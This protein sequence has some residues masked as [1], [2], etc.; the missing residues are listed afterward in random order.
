MCRKGLYFF[1]GAATVLLVPTFLNAEGYSLPPVECVEVD[2]VLYNS[3]PDWMSY[4][5][6]LSSDV[7]NPFYAA[8]IL[9]LSRDFE[10][11][12]KEFLF[13]PLIP[14]AAFAPDIIERNTG[15][16]P[17][18]LRS[19]AQLLVN[20]FSQHGIS[21]IDL[22]EAAAAMPDGVNYHR[23]TDH[24]WTTEGAARSA[25]LVANKMGLGQFL[26]I[27]EWQDEYLTFPRVG[28]KSYLP[29][30]MRSVVVD[31]CQLE[32]FGITFDLIDFPRAESSQSVGED[33]LFGG[34]GE[35]KIAVLGSSYTAA[36]VGNAFP[37][38]LEHYAQTT[39]L[40]YSIGGGGAATSLHQFTS[41]DGIQ[42]DSVS[43]VVWVPGTLSQLDMISGAALLGS[44]SLEQECSSDDLFYS[45]RILEANFDEWVLLPE[46]IGLTDRIEIDSLKNVQVEFELTVTGYEPIVVNAFFGGGHNIEEPFKWQFKLP[47]AELREIADA[48]IETV[49]VRI[50]GFR[51]YVPSGP[52][53]FG[54]TACSSL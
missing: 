15:F 53:S 29:P 41:G 44:G 52:V 34:G 21:S 50:T 5:S 51:D 12:G 27:F 33:A 26:S 4:R 9:Q 38:A 24:H 42:N 35:M 54:V 8:S 13:L 30:I 10:D 7:Y 20:T 32:D 18:D 2:R 22:S 14:P 36:D 47:V 37:K 48:E 31:D 25:N 45:E 1:L 49:Q 11:L 43:N 6:Y 23:L 16:S 39:V 28:Q 19:S 40:D 46:V 3:D 17:Q